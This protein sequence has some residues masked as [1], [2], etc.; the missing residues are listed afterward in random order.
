ML[1]SQKST[2]SPGQTASFNNAPIASISGQQSSLSAHEDAATK[3]PIVLAAVTALY[4]LWAVIERHNKVQDTVKPA[5]AA[6][7]L[8]FIALVTLAAI[9]G[10]N[11]LVVLF[12]KLV[13]WKVPGARVMLHLLG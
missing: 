9:V 4:I 11:L 1:G 3:T 12:T 7:N 13:V 5:N 2:S 8:R 6:V 10:R